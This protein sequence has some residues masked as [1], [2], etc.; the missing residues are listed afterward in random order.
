M[1]NV[2][3]SYPGI[4]TLF[5]TDF[6]IFFFVVSCAMN[7]LWLGRHREWGLQLLM[8]LTV[9]AQLATLCITAKIDLTC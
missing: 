9:K 6:E 4:S 8:F 1:S 3:P 5:V 7:G 2:T